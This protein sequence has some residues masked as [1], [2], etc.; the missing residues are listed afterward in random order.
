MV[1]GPELPEPERRARAVRT[2]ATCAHNA[3]DLAALLEMLGLRADEARP[4]RLP[5]SQTAPEVKRPNKHV[6][7]TELR[8]QAR[9]AYRETHPV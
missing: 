6:P 8:E 3:E 1:E 2:V 5:A 7:I 9:A 4:Q